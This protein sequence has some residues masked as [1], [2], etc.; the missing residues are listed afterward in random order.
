MSTTK[1]IV[2]DNIELVDGNTAGNDPLVIRRWTRNVQ[3][4]VNFIW[5]DRPWPWKVITD[6]AFAFDPSGPVALPADFGGVEAEGA[7]VYSLQPRA[8]CRPMTIGEMNMAQ[9]GTQ[10]QTQAF[11]PWTRWAIGNGTLELWP[12]LPGADTICFVYLK[13]RPNCVYELSP[14]LDELSWIPEQWHD[15]VSDGARLYNAHDVHSNQ[16]STEQA[17][18]KLGLDQMRGREIQ[19]PVKLVPFMRRRMNR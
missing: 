15:L 1:E 6:T 3:R 7:G 13:R 8:A 11:G 2:D 18:V 19:L 9:R 10:L 12:T 5:N 17:F 16:E 14:S 4:A